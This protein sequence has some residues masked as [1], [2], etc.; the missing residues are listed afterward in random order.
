MQ[1]VTTMIYKQLFGSVCALGTLALLGSICSVAQAQSAKPKFAYGKKSDR[2]LAKELWKAL[3]SNR[4]VGRERINV[5]AFEGKRP[6]G[7]VQQIYT[8][9]IKVK[10]RQGRA[11]VKANHT[12]KGVTV[13]NVYDSPNKYLSGYTVMFANKPGYDPENNDW[14]WVHYRTDGRVN[15]AAN[16][17]AVAGRV[18]KLSDYGCISCHRKIGGDDLE[19]LT[20]K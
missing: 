2:Q 1:A 12:K 16:G 10:G 17:L 3:R 15:Q 20:S 9:T 14:F 8:A 18:G 13:Q 7:A 6:H 5:H 4:M 11:I 19:A